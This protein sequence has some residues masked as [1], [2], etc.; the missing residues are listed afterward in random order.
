MKILVYNL[1]IGF[2]LL[3][4]SLWSLAAWADGVQDFTK[5]I[6]KEFD[7]NPEGLTGISNKYGKVVVKTWDRNRTKIEVKITAKASSEEAARKVFD[8]IKID[9]SNAPDLVRAATSI[10][11]GKSGW[12]WDWSWF[13][14]SEKTEYTID[15]DVTMPVK[16]RLDLS[17]KYGDSYLGT[18]GGRTSLT[19]KYGNFTI[20]NMNDYLRFDLGYGNGTVARS[21]DVSGSG[22][23]CQ[24]RLKDAGDVDIQ[25]KYSKISIEQAGDVRCTSAYDSYKL[26]DVRDMRNQGKYDH[27]EIGFAENVVMVSKYTDV[28]IEK[29]ANSADLDLDYGSAT[30]GHVAKGFGEVR[31]IGSYADFKVKV[32]EG[33]TYQVDA[34]A[35]YAGIR[36]PTAMQVSFEKE[37]GTSHEVNGYVGQKGARSVIKAR[38]DYGGL[39]VW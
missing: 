39:K 31:L 17:N 6:K 14:G 24:L 33:A 37:E 38:L 15:Y 29:L 11:S 30:L 16:G 25:T 23:Y 2:V 5:V 28:S 20:E 9:F 12:G 3:C 32:E 7:I 22:S 8:Q 35:D 36:Y 19:I 21:K 1:K 26:G 34:Q 4:A 10:E 13:W 18:I 27:F